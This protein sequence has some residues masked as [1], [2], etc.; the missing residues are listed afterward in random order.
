MI[1]I[2]GRSLTFRKDPL[3]TP[4]PRLAV[5][6]VF[7]HFCL[8]PY[9]NYPS[10]LLPSSPFSGRRDSERIS[11]SFSFS[12]F[13]IKKPFNIFPKTFLLKIHIYKYIYIYVFIFNFLRKWGKEKRIKNLLYS[14]LV[15][16]SVPRYSKLNSGCFDRTACC[17]FLLH[18]PT[19]TNGLSGSLHR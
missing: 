9:T 10:P 11:F 5:P 12:F 7:L 15:E 18:G 17:F 3:P 8:P 13:E 14:T 16:P 4:S 6:F 2:V 1:R 19:G